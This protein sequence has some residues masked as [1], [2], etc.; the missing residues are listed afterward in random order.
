M[1]VSGTADVTE[2]TESI[3]VLHEKLKAY[4]IRDKPTDTRVIDLEEYANLI[5]EYPSLSPDDPA[6]EEEEDDDMVEP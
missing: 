5:S 3:S 1:I 4:F 2:A 6:D